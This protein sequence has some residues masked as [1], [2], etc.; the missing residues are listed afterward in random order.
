V[1]KK[2]RNHRGAK[3]QGQREQITQRATDPHKPGESD[4][5]GRNKEGGRKGR[6]CGRGLVCHA[7]F[8]KGNWEER[9]KR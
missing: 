8:S 6:F 5:P 4:I 3:L 9:N 2:Q 1:T 7:G